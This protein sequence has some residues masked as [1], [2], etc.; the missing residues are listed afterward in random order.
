MKTI[1]TTELTEKLRNKTSM[2]SIIPAKMKGKKFV[3]KYSIHGNMFETDFAFFQGDEGIPERVKE[4][5]I[6]AMKVIRFSSALRREV[7]DV[8]IYGYYTIGKVFIHRVE[9]SS[10]PNSPS[11]VDEICVKLL[12]GRC[13]LIQ[14]IGIGFISRVKLMLRKLM[15]IV[16]IQ[17]VELKT[18]FYWPT[19]YK[20]KWLVYEEYEE[21]GLQYRSMTEDDV[22]KDNLFDVCREHEYYAE[23]ATEDGVERYL[24]I[25]D[26]KTIV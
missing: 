10:V 5:I 17:Q 13:L 16:N 11:R 23:L 9:I 26:Y 8:T 6:T 20:S 3:G 4:D 15:G 24:V 1:T 22:I 2:L 7:G 14:K 21:K 18:K 25:Q 12:R 19:K